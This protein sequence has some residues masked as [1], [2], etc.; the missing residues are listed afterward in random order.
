MQA[1]LCRA[2]SEIDPPAMEAENEAAFSAYVNL[3]EKLA[4]FGERPRQAL[5]R[6]RAVHLQVTEGGSG[7]VYACQWGGGRHVQPA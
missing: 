3:V 2:V 7:M 6:M 1:L 5:E 4:T